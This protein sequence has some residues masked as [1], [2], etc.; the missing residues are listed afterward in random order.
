MADELTRLSRSLGRRGGLAS[1]MV[2]CAAAL[3]V[4]QFHGPSSFLVRASARVPVM[5]TLPSVAVSPHA[6]GKS[7]EVRVRM[8]LPGDSIEY[9]LEVYGDPTTLSYEWVRLLDTVGVDSARPLTGA[10]LVAPERPGFYRLALLSGD[11]RRILDDLTVTV[12]VPFA[13]KTGPVLNGYRI[14]TYL[15][16]RLGGQR[17]HPEGFIE[18]LDRQ[19]AALRVSRHLRLGDMLTRDGQT[20]WPRYLVLSPELLD[21]VE[22]VLDEL[23]V[24]RGDSTPVELRF[25]VSAGYRTPSFNS[26]I[27]LAASNSRHQHGDAVDVAIDADGDGRFTARDVQLV[28]LAVEQVERN[29]PDLV[30]GLGQYTSRRYNTPFA[31]IDVRGQRARWQG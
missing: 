23:A 4:L 20:Q 15:A 10:S 21:K 31:H 27:K 19:L 5:A 1:V 7:G 26:T 8:A 9:P 24:I 12:L 11:E 3:G 16:E 30:G 25:N 29:H 2:C 22:L 6:F 18:V 13:D 17:D 28:A 14:G